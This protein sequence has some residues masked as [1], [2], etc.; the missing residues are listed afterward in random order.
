M[1]EFFPMDK[2]SYYSSNVANSLFSFIK[3]IYS[4]VHGV[5]SNSTNHIY[6]RVNKSLSEILILIKKVFTSVSKVNEKENLTFFMGD[7]TSSKFTTKPKFKPKIFNGTSS[8]DNTNSESSNN[9]DNRPGPSE[10]ALGKRV[11]R[12]QG[13]LSPQES[14]NSNNTRLGKKIK[15]EQGSLSPKGSPSSPSSPSIK[16]E[17]RIKL[18]QSE[19][20]SLL[21]IPP[22]DTSSYSSLGQSAFNAATAV[23]QTKPPSNSGLIAINLGDI[24]VEKNSVAHNMFKQVAKTIP[25]HY[26][27]NIS[28]SLEGKA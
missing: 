18:E 26:R 7:D 2:L 5:I 1:N 16:S 25:T 12:E 3:G 17:G 14:P 4:Y 23:A 13:S 21:T 10:T 28:T 11:K 6:N 22:L 19:S 24:K 27:T 8:M 9:G 15:V 20:P